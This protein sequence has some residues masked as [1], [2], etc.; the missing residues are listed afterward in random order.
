MFRKLAYLTVVLLTLLPFRVFADND[1]VCRE[2][3]LRY[4]KAKEAY[5]EARVESITHVRGF[6]I[7]DSCTFV[8]A[9]I[10][11]VRTAF[12]LAPEKF[13]ADNDFE[14]AVGDS[15]SI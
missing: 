6:S 3:S 7:S 4:D 8:L 5:F 14:V 15:V 13:L 2:D 11:G 9:S 12:Y 1:A 10:A